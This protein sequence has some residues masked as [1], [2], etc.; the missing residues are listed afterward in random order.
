MKYTEN[1]SYSVHTY[2]I[3]TSLYFWTQPRRTFGNVNVRNSGEIFSKIKF[4]PAAGTMRYKC[5]HFPPFPSSFRLLLCSDCSKTLSHKRK[6]MVVFELCACIC[7]T[8]TLNACRQRWIESHFNQP[9]FQVLAVVL[10][11]R[12]I[13]HLSRAAFLSVWRNWFFFLNRHFSLSYVVFY[14]IFVSIM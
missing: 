8:N 13:E 1:S 14:W 5:K 11:S 12:R 10:N 3:R 7:S 9:N 6:W 4:S 2:T